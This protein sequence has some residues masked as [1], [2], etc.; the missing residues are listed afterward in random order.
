MFLSGRNQIIDTIKKRQPE[1]L[2]LIKANA[3]AAVYAR[4]E[5]MPFRLSIANACFN[6]SL[7][8]LFLNMVLQ[9]GKGNSAEQQQHGIG[10]NGLGCK[11]RVSHPIGANRHQGKPEQQIDIA[12][13]NGGVDPANGMQQVVMVHPIDANK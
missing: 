11:T 4:I 1:T 9:D 6:F 3:K 13:Q 12:P 8:P 5:K 10:C 2:V 7:S